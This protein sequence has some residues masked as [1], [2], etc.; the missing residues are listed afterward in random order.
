MSICCNR[1]SFFSLHSIVEHFLLDIMWMWCVSPQAPP[2]GSCWSRLL[3]GKSS[4]SRA[5]AIASFP[6]ASRP[7]TMWLEARMLKPDCLGP[8][9]GFTAYCI[10]TLRLCFLTCK[11]SACVIGLSTGWHELTGATCAAERLAYG[12][13]T[14][15]GGLLSST[16]SGDAEC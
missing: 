12:K 5:Q 2:F 4:H 9:L 16:S 3:T 7:S 6:C 13:R 14:V 8:D 1:I 15:R 10:I 11:I